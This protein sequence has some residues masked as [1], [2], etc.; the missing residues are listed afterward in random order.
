M[1]MLKEQPSP[2]I[3][4]LERRV[5][6]GAER[7]WGV[8]LSAGFQRDR[9]LAAYASIEKSYRAILENRDPIII[10]GTFRSRG[11]QTFY[12]VRVGADTRAAAIALCGALHRAGGACS[13]LRN[14]R[15]TVSVD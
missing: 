6:E 14:Q 1:A 13:V 5:R 11:T 10:A 7:P 12:Q 3:G 4:E 2:F 9:V 15:E 8:Q